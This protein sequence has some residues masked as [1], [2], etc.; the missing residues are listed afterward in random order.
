GATQDTQDL[1]IER[2]LVNAAGKRVGGIQHLI[3]SW[4]NTYGPWRS[5][6]LT[7]NCFLRGD[8]SHPRLGARRNGNIQFDL[9]QEFSIRIEDLNAEVAAIGNIDVA[10]RV[11][12]NTVGRVELTRLGSGFAK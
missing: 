8:G 6:M 2:E 3:G 11:C 5:R 12:S 9:A 4:R 7:P 1:S 10:L